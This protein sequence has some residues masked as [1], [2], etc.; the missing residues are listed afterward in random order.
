MKR[1]MKHVG[2]VSLLLG[3]MTGFLV[4]GM[5]MAIAWDHNPQ[6]EFY[7]PGN[8]HWGD[9]IMLGVSWLVPTSGAVT[10][11]SF[12]LGAGGMVLIRHIRRNGVYPCE[13]HAL[14]TPGTHDDF[15]KN[16]TKGVKCLDDWEKR[17]IYNTWQA[18]FGVGA[19]PGI[20]VWPLAL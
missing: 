10:I 17:R 7:E 3:I 6:G 18:S 2:I 16:S 14:S 19:A 13:T 8:V 9:W 4:G 15:S 12:C 5:M 11:L 20:L 1:R